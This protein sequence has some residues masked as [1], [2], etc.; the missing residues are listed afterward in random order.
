MAKPRL[1]RNRPDKSEG[2]GDGTDEDEWE[3]EERQSRAGL[4]TEGAHLPH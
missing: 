2:P 1:F 4:E 3:G